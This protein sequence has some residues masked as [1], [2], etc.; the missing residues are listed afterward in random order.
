MAENIIM[1]A[2]LILSAALLYYAI[3]RLF[4]TIDP[5]RPE[6][7]ETAEEKYQIALED[8]V[9]ARELSRFLKPEDCR[10]LTGTTEEIM[11]EIET[12]RVDMAVLN[13]EHGECGR[14]MNHVRVQYYAS[15][16]ALR[17]NDIDIQLLKHQARTIEVY[18]K[19][20]FA[21]VIAQM[22]DKGVIVRT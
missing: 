17:E 14:E 16:L 8:L 5:P 3:G 19:D 13:R 6:K 10:Y 18:Y 20:R 9:F 11:T 12:D 1:I 21:P 2:G 22:M 7:T 4:D 15:V